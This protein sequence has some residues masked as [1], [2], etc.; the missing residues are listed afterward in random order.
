MIGGKVVKNPDDLLDKNGYTCLII[1]E[2]K[3]AQDFEIYESE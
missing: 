3:A 1:T 2:A